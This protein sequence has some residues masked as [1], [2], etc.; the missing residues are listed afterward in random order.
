MQIYTGLVREFKNYFGTE[1]KDT[2]TRGF[3]NIFYI[4][5]SRVRD[6]AFFFSE[7]SV[8]L[9]NILINDFKSNYEVIYEYFNE[10]IPDNQY[11]F[12]I[13]EVDKDSNEIDSVRVAYPQVES[14]EDE[15]SKRY[16]IKFLYFKE[17]LEE[18]LYNLPVKL[19]P[20][21]SAKNILAQGVFNRIHHINNYF[22][23][24]LEKNIIKSVNFKT[25][26]LYRGIIPLLKYKNWGKENL[27]LVEKICSTSSFHHSLAYSL[28]MESIINISVS[29][30][31]KMI[32][33]I[34]CELERITNHIFWFVNLMYLTY[35][36]KEYHTLLKKVLYFLNFLEKE[37][38]IRYFEELNY[39]GYV[40]D[41]LWYSLEDLRETVEEIYSSSFKNIYNS[42]YN[43]TLKKQFKGL[44]TLLEENVLESGITGPNVRASGHIYDVRYFS[45]Y[46][47]YLDEDII[48][49]WEVVTF[50]GGDAY[51]R[52]QVRLWELKNSVSI[53]KGAIDY[54]KN[55]TT[56]IEVLDFANIKLIADKIGI[57]VVEAPQGELVYIVKTS[58]LPGKNNLGS[59]SIQTPSMNNFFALKN[60]ILPNC[61]IKDFPLIVHSMDLCFNCID[62]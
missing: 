37:L 51:S 57:S 16:G 50:N 30:R 10:Y 17:E 27:A 20:A 46:N 40:K 4:N 22:H 56:K 19:F 42:I 32:R 12:V 62:L 18:S 47:S 60:F 29:N 36:F 3:A 2:P 11:L 28:A 34:Y 44:S 31:V 52:I 43:S 13:T 5:K 14:Y 55:D 49:K 38:G 54:L 48:D 7:K 45:P 6:I 21:H 58:D 53:I 61:D 15:I 26:W 8:N 39:I 23:C 33:T 24:N 35:S 1:L 9:K 59:V 41:I 25:G